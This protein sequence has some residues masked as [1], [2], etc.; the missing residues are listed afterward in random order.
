MPLRF[1]VGLGVPVALYLNRIFNNQNRAHEASHEASL[2]AS[3]MHVLIESCNYN[4]H[5]LRMIVALSSDGEIMRGP[6]LRTTTWDALCGIISNHLTEPEL[7]QL[8]SH[9]WIRLKRLEEL[10]AYTFSMQIG[11]SPLP[12]SNSLSIESFIYEL[13]ITANDL[14]NHASDLATKLRCVAEQGGTE[15]FVQGRWLLRLITA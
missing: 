4:V 12:S 2:L 9:H 11:Q 1:G 13:H 14:A 15:Q 6:D 5:V 8:L 3:A 7:L 10:N